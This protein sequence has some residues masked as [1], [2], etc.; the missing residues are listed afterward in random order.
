MY[1]VNNYQNDWDAKPNQRGGSTDKLP[2]GS[3]Y[4]II[5]LNEPGV[6]PIQGWLY[7]NY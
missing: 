2:V 7:I 3:Y 5:N 4:Y 6:S 1:Q